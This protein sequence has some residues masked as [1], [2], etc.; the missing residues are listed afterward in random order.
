MDTTILEVL[1]AG[2]IV[3]AVV[4]LLGVP[5]AMLVAGVAVLVACWR[6]E[7]ERAKRRVRR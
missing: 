4:M 1:G 7:S 3:A 5:A 2:L 6:I